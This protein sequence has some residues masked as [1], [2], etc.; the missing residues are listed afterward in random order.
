MSNDATTA[1][2]ISAMSTSSQM[3]YD[4]SASKKKNERM[5]EF[6]KK[7]N[8][9]NHPRQQMQRLQEAGLN[10]NL[11][12]GDSVSGA[13]GRAD[14]I[15]TPDKP[16]SKNPIADITAFQDVRARKA[17]ADLLEQQVTT[18]MERKRLVSNQAD[19]TY[20]DAANVNYS[21][22]SNPYTQT[23][24]QAMKLRNEQTKRNIIGKEIENDIKNRTKA[25]QVSRIFWEAQNA[26]ETYKGRKL[27]NRLL[28]LQ[29]QF[30]NLG[31]DRNS[32]W[33]AKIFGNIINKSQN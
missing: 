24:L 9:Y 8:K 31:L 29:R 1:A 22:P 10:P 21:D 26:E 19:K 14:S 25:E 2:A 4:A 13:T 20:Y 3:A 15:G 7:Q 33:Y 18:E 12:Y 6:W 23:S 28:E 5:I 11:I 32:P 16:E 27:N 17:Q 30:L